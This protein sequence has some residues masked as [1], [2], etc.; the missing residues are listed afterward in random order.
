MEYHV[1]ENS[2]Y[3][4]ICPYV[5]K[6]KV[7]DKRYQHKRWYM[8]QLVFQLTSNLAELATRPIPLGMMKGRIPMNHMMPVRDNGKPLLKGKTTP[9][10]IVERSTY[11]SSMLHWD[12][13]KECRYLGCYSTVGQNVP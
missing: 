2:H 11:N 3:A 8:L 5:I 12:K 7:L 9:F 6:A 4:N 10:G 13:T 1:C